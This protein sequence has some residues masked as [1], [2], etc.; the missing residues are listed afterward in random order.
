M[1]TKFKERLPEETIQ[2]VTD[3]LDNLGLKYEF[4]NVVSDI[5]GLYSCYLKISNFNFTVGGKGTSPLYAQAS[6]C[7]EVMERLQNLHNIKLPIQLRDG[8]SDF[9]YF[10]DES[11]FPIGNISSLPDEVIRDMQLYCSQYDGYTPTVSELEDIW[12]KKFPSMKEVPF[13]GVKNGIVKLPF[14]VVNFLTKSNGMSAGNSFNEALVQGLSEVIERY[15]I[16]S[17]L[18][19]ELCPPEIPMEYV[20]KHAPEMYNILEY[21]NTDKYGIKIFDGSLGKGLPVVGI[22][23]TDRKL[24]RYKVKFGAHPVFR[25]ALERC[26]TELFQYNSF[27]YKLLRVH[28]KWTGETSGKAKSYSNLI[29]CVS[30]NT[31][32]FPDNFFKKKADWDFKEW[33]EIPAYTNAKGSKYLIDLCLRFTSDI[34]IREHSYS[35][36]TALKVYL[37]GMNFAH[38][39]PLTKDFHLDNYFSIQ[40]QNLPSCIDSMSIEEKR[41][42]IDV[43][44]KDIAFYNRFRINDSQFSIT[45]SLVSAFLYLDLGELDNAIK[46]FEKSLNDCPE[47]DVPLISS[48]LRYTELV[49]QGYSFDDIEYMMEFFYKDKVLN[50]LKLIHEGRYYQVLF[51]G[52]GTDLATLKEGITEFTTRYKQRMKDNPI[53]QADLKEKIGLL[54]VGQ[55]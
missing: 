20:E 1:E 53:N 44:N 12:S 13:Y 8:Y 23:L 46:E 22:L 54:G 10:P 43:L 29:K 35:G 45:D 31:N 48:I 39:E 18:N 36:F 55:Q 52:E 16:Y 34:Y 37:P 49:Q 40:M 33:E 14:E 51:D 27:A 30:K 42:V 2:I 7:G 50:N 5:S 47:K 21:I 25:I 24:K 6:A 15:S 11:V 4:T 38:T 3:I 32:S 41:K 9:E 17:I 26:L 19:G 28:S